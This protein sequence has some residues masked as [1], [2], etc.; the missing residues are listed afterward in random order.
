MNNEASI[1]ES[2]MQS[3][4]KFVPGVRVEHFTQQLAS[5]HVAGGSPYDGDRA[6]ADIYDQIHLSLTAHSP[7]HLL[8]VRDQGVGDHMVMVELARQ[9]LAGVRD[10]LSDARFVH[11][12]ASYIASDHVPHLLDR[13]TQMFGGSADAVV[14]IDGVAALLDSH[15]VTRSRKALLA[16]LSTVQCRVIVALGEHEVDELIPDVFERDAFFRTL[17]LP[18]PALPTAMNLV[19]RYAA[20]MEQQYEVRIAE[21]AITAAV[22]LTSRFVVSQRLPYKAVRLLQQLCEDQR[23]A[24]RRSSQDQDVISDRHVLTALAKQTGIPET[25]LDGTGDGLDYRSVLSAAIVGQTHAVDDIAMELGL[26]RAGFAEPAKPA[27]VMLFVGPTGTGKTEMA[28]VLASIYSRSKR[29]TTFT[30]GNFSEPHSVSGIIGVPAGY[31]GHDRGGRLINELNADP[32]GVFL[33]DEA[34]KAHPDVMQPFLNLFDE[35]WIYDQRGVKAYADRAMFILTTNVGQRQIVDMC[36]DGKTIGEMTSK[37][38]ES[39]AQIRHSKSN[40]PVF[41]PEFL[42]RIKRVVVF[43]SLDESAMRGVTDRLFNKMQADWRERRQRGLRVDSAVIDWI[44]ERAH[45]GNED[46]KHREGGRIVRKL[47][48]DCVESAIQKTIAHSPEDYRRCH[49]VDVCLAEADD[50]VEE[51]VPQVSVT[52]SSQPASRS[53]A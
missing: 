3:A 32:Y 34:D 40:R 12:D 46:S 49:V 13:L 10:G 31:V 51:M 48:A 25:T 37:I 22:N 45:R 47:I 43:R 21:D 23:F 6:Y 14:H 24:R 52:F 8:L 4:T 9:C 7:R 38:K 33:L 53:E 41:T 44:A 42:A 17:F 20:G 5:D 2:A 28:K 36:R 27:S 50:G 26:I 30:L 29:L 19:A 11:V 15:D 16:W 18:E 1:S 39:L 35:G